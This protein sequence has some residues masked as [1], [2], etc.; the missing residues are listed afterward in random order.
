MR[1]GIETEGPIRR[2]GFEGAGAVEGAAAALVF[3]TL[4]DGCTSAVFSVDEAISKRPARL[5]VTRRI[6]CWAG[7]GEWS[8]SREENTLS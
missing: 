7:Q 4:G 1:V 5:A 8:D 2:A 6:E 3:D